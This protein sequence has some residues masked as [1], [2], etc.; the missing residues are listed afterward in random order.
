MHSFSARLEQCPTIAA[1][2]SPQD[3]RAALEAPAG[4]IFVLHGSILD[5][6]GTVD[7]IRAA[8]KL[9][10]VHI[11]LLE[12]L[13]AKEVAVDYLQAATGADG[14][15]STKPL[16]IRRAKELGLLAVQR[17]FLLDSM[18][19]ENVRKQMIAS[20]A[21]A[22]E[23]LPGCMPKII[24]QLAAQSKKPL[25]ASGLMLDKEDV[26]AALSAG[27][28]AVSTTNEAIWQM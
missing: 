9:S 4:L 3:L 27:A 14:I 23:I 8:G 11:D 24:R 22:V 1:I 16:L 13:S 17:F 7:A 2:K 12:G 6:S 28:A 5:I 26:I 18:A 25:I 21:D 10:L 15:I 20:P 19:L